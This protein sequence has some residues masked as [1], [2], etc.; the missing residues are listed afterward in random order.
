M[1]QSRPLDSLCAELKQPL[2]PVAT[3]ARCMQRRRW[4]GAGVRARTGMGAPKVPK[5]PVVL[6]SLIALPGGT[7][8]PPA[9]VAAWRA[10]A[11]GAVMGALKRPKAPS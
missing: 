3:A 6:R 11:S 8:R 10:A 7:S 5:M 2:M 1:R 9:A 4:C